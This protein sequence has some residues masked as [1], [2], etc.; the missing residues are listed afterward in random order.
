MVETWSGSWFEEGT[1]VFYVVP[2]P[3]VDLTL[4][5][6]IRPRPGMVERVFVGRLEIAT[7]WLLDD[8]RKAIATF[9]E[10]TLAA[11]GRFLQPFGQRILDNDLPADERARIVAALAGK[12][13]E[14]RSV[15]PCETTTQSGG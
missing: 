3:L 8:L 15:R 4:P 12:A 5:L 2:R 7:P 9:D 10:E 11:R 13:S 14:T 6:N 1:R